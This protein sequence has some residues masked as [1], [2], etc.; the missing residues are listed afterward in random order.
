[1]D[2]YSKHVTGFSFLLL[3]LVFSTSIH[4]QNISIP[5]ITGVDFDTTGGSY[6]A[7]FSTNFNV[8]GIDIT[9]SGL[10][11]SYNDGDETLSLYGTASATF[12]GETMDVG[13]GDSGNPGL[14]ITNGSLTQ[15]NFNI[16]SQFSLNSLSLTPVDLGMWWGVGTTS[17]SIL[18]T[19]KAA[20][21]TDTLTAD[22]GGTVLG[23]GITVTNG[24][25][26]D[27]SMTISANFEIESLSITPDILAFSY[28]E[29]DSRYEIWGDVTVDVDG[30]EV[31]GAFGT[32]DNPG[33]LITNG[34][35]TSFNIGVTGDFDLKA[36]TIST[37]NLTF[38]WDSGNSQFEM[39]GS[40]STTIDGNDIDIS[41]GDENDPG[42][43]VSSGTVTH[44]N[45]GVTADFEMKGITISPD[46]LTLEYDSGNSQ[47]E[48]YGSVAVKFDGEEVDAG[49]G[50]SNDPGIIFKSGSITHVNF[51]LTADFEIKSLAVIPT[52]LTFEY[53]ESNSH[54]E[55]Y[56]DLTFKIGNDELTANM[57]DANDPGLTYKN[58]SIQ[59]VNIGVTSDFSLE[60]LKI[61]TTNLG[62][63]WNSGSDYHIYGDADLSIDSETIDVDFGTFNEP[64]IVVRNGNLHSFEVDVNSDLKLGNL[65]VETKDLDIKYSSNK[66]EVTGEMAITEVFSLSVTLGEGSQGGP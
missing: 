43:I 54:F 21:G 57:G 44:I 1:M 19:L 53:D 41:L 47:Y 5:G 18:G 15:V 9:S 66:Y 3:F 22:L 39:F 58:N 24:A 33:F 2:F 6:T 26:T 20:V 61:K 55:M 60:G 51:E 40:A 14:V 59:H 38:Q 34:S 36:I 12:E 65:E 17:F 64:G 52:N 48:F 27:I 35:L 16:T 32:F 11:L 30:N 42:L 62:A 37:D 63:E 4:A 49:L 31:A 23:P 10:T 25:V 50:D 7:S 29:A 45:F 56:G 8:H 46:A 28:S 13:F